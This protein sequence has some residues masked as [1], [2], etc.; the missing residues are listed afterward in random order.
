MAPSSRR[1]SIEIQLRTPATALWVPGLRRIVT[2]A[3]RIH[4]LG[5][6][7]LAGNVALAVTEACSNTV[8]HAYPTGPGDIL[9]ELDITDDAVTA[10]VTD[11]GVGIHA[12][13]ADPGAG[14]GLRLI[15]ATSDTTIHSEPGHTRIEMRF[16]ANPD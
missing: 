3:L 14:F 8:R 1:A 11:H 16:A 12:A 6:G 7:H 2:H 13:T 9:L 5:S 4:D 15:H 10:T